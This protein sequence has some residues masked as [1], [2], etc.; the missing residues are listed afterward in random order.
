[1]LCAHLMIMSR[2]RSPK[3]IL[4]AGLPLLCFSEPSVLYEV[5]QKKRKK[6]KQSVLSLSRQRSKWI[7]DR[8][9]QFKYKYKLVLS[10]TLSLANGKTTYL[11]LFLNLEEKKY[12]HIFLRN[13]VSIKY[14]NIN[15]RAIQYVLEK[16]WSSEEQC[17]EYAY[18]LKHKRKH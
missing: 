9:E 8:K 2:K 7:T 3:A 13:A 6:K 16:I 14:N 1:M 4:H 10:L 18:F 11:S 5:V 17:L 15:A 12:I